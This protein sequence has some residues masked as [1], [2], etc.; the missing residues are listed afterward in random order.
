MLSFLRKRRRKIIED[1]KM[2]KVL[3]YA[4]GEILLVVIGILIAVQINNWNT[5]RKL[6]KSETLTLNRL[7]EDLKSDHRRYNFLDS[8]LQHHAQLCDSVIS[9]IESQNTIKDRIDL[10]S[11][12]AI[13]VFLLEPNTTT[14]D[15]MKNTGRLYSLSDKN[16]RRDITLYYRQ[17]NKWDAYSEVNSNTIRN[18]VNDPDLRDYW[19]IKT[20]I[21]KGKEISIDK[22]PWLKKTTS[23]EL[24]AIEYLMY[25]TSNGL[26]NNNSNYQ[27]IKEIRDPLLSK[28]DSRD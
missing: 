1:S 25:A 22:F 28:L 27:I 24:K 23:K 18:L 8:A 20:Q 16:L 4:L 21:D 14:Y 12:D 15:E 10:I 6:E 3:I 2:K 17:L 13:E 7:F 11:I 26:K 9:L 19:M 5:I